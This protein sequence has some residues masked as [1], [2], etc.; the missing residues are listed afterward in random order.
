MQDNKTNHAI[1]RYVF[2]VSTALLVGA[3]LSVMP[4]RAGELVYTPVNPSFGGHPQNGPY[5]MSKAQAGKKY[6]MD[7][8]FPEF[9]MGVMLIAQIEGD[10][11]TDTL[12]FQ[13][14]GAIY[15]Y[16]V[17]TGQVRRTELESGSIDQLSGINAGDLE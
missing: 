11:G 8:D 10:N 16:D 2:A 3:A 7:I 4:A 13:K 14:D 6:K 1:G 12:L 5:L 17:K 15:A 9:D